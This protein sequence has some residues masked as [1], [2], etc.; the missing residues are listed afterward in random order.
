MARRHPAC[1]GPAQA[2]RIRSRTPKLRCRA[3][4]PKKQDIMTYQLIFAANNGTMGMEF[5]ATLPDGSGVTSLGD[6][7][8]GPADSFLDYQGGAAGRTFYFLA[9]DG[10]AGQELWGTDGTGAGTRLIADIDPGPNAAY[11]YFRGD[12]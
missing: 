4:L 5:Y 7:Y 1:T 12:R 2:A 10:V 6:L 3:S 8:P 9:N 11:P